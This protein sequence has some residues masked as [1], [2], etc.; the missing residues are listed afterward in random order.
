MP[1]QKGQA[2]TQEKPLSTYVSFPDGTIYE[3]VPEGNGAVRMV[4]APNTL[5]AGTMVMTPLAEER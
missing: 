1:F 3:A 5:P 2:K 4:P